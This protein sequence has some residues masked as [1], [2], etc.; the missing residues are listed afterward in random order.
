MAT[1]T[2]RLRST[3]PGMLSLPWFRPLSEWSDAGVPFH[4]MPV[5]A[6][7]HIV[8]FV[9]ADGA[10]FALKELPIRVARGEY[11]VLRALENRDFPAV[12][13]VGLVERAEDGD[14]I[15]VTQF[16]ERSFQFRRLF[17]RLPLESRAPRERLL[18]AMASLLVDLHRVGVFWGDCSLANTLFRRD[19]QILQAFLVDA[20]TSETH[21]SLTDGQRE[22]DLDI[23]VE[24][25]AGDLADLGAMLG[26]P[27]D[28]IDE[29]LREADSVV[30]RYR[31]LWDE[32]HGVESIAADET[33]RIEARIRRLNDLG[34]TIDEV[35]LEPDGERDRVRLK[36][37]VTSRR[38]HAQELR[39]RTGLEV[40]EGQATILLN[41]LRAYRGV[42]ER[43]I[44]APVPREVAA[45][46]WLAEV[47]RPA[48]QRLASS[49]HP[50]ADLIQGYCDLT[51]VRWLLSERAGHDVGDD[52]AVEALVDSQAPPESAALMAVAESPTGVFSLAWG[53]E[54]APID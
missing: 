43:R 46:R 1:P 35:D 54:R 38:F 16:L 26:R 8:R 25:V 24:N 11:E 47:V 17:Q 14:A 6:S 33:Y 9:D 32:L 22:F 12:R 39:R 7:R 5:G 42:L 40:G 51:E 30:R 10:T 34:F 53:D 49:E 28:L 13:P 36:V 31:A 50:P 27:P 23:L 2:I 29:D 52:A 45:E 18:D 41:D 4:E 19:G 15:L 48:M 3:G 37:A 20:E 21:P 44:G